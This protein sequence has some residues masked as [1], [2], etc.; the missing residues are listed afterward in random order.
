MWLCWAYS[1]EKVPW[2]VRTP[3]DDQ[4]G[5]N[6]PPCP[7]IRSWFC[8]RIPKFIET[9]ARPFRLG[10]WEDALVDEPAL[11]REE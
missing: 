11:Y 2:F 7:G 1:G 6:C 9:L 4:T 10:S 8:Y 3:H 5:Y